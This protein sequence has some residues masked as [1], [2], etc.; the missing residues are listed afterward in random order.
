VSTT[1]RRTPRASGRPGGFV[2]WRA[3]APDLAAVLAIF[4]VALAVRAPFLSDTPRYTDEMGEVLRAFDV[5]RGIGLP[6]TNVDAY[7]GPFW[8]YLLAAAMWLFGPT[9]ELP[10][11]VVLVSG[12]LTVAATYGLGRQ[13]AGR[14]AGL[15]AAALLVGAP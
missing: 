2:A 10:R 6:L 13:V 5:Y 8:N 1:A 15:L 9:P 4:G 11:R 12:A 14:G 3:G 7:I